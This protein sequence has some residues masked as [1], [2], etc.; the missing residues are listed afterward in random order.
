LWF[1]WFWIFFFWLFYL[2]SDS[3]NVKVYDPHYEENKW[4]CMTLYSLYNLAHEDFY[5]RLSRSTNIFINWSLQGVIIA[6]I[7][8]SQFMGAP[9]IIWTALIAFVVTIPIPFILG[10]IIHKKI[11]E[12]FMIKYENMKSMKGIFDK[13][14]L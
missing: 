3:T 7:Y 12:K 5:T 2:L 6:S 14:K 13:S 8:G 10:A 4:T 11:Y 9:M 1:A